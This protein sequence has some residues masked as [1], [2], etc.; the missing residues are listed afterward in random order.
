[1]TNFKSL[2]FFVFPLFLLSCKTTQ[3]ETK[4]QVYTSWDKGFLLPYRSFQIGELHY[5]SKSDPLFTSPIVQER[6]VKEIKFNFE[7]KNLK[8]KPREGDVLIYPFFIGNKLQAPILPYEMAS[9]TIKS[10]LFEI[11]VDTL[12]VNQRILVL[13]M[14]DSGTNQLVWR[15]YSKITTFP[16]ELFLKEITQVIQEIAKKYPN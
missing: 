8:Y 4:T 16:Q 9:A 14:V 13:D 11:S 10:D 7:P 3:S 12:E 15:A 5:S 2:L 1:M 6:L